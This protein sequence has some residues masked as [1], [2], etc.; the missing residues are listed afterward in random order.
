MRIELCYPKCIEALLTHKH[1]SIH[2]KD[3]QGRTPLEIAELL[4]DVA[5][6]EKYSTS[7]QNYKRI[8]A[9]LQSFSLSDHEI[10]NLS[11]TVI[12]MRDHTSLEVSDE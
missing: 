2:L 9:F 8:L 3:E 1:I 11:A 4:I 10:Q 6:D 12:S 5:S 7:K